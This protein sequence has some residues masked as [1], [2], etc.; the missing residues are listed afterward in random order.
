M[1]NRNQVEPGTLPL[2]L[3]ILEDNPRD[4]KLTTS[5]LKREGLAFEF[6]VTDSAEEFQERLRNDE[7][8]IVVADFNL[9]GWTALHALEIV[10]R[11]GK[12]IPVIVLTGSI[13]DEAAVDLIKRGA[14]D[15]ILK[16]R[17]ARLPLAIRQAVEE[18]RLRQERE[19]A[20]AAVRES[21]ERYRTLFERNL[22]GVIRTTRDGQ[23][24]ECNQAMADIL[25]Y[26]SPR[27]VRNL[28]ASDLYVFPVERAGF[29]EKLEAEG[30]LT[31]YEV[32]WRRKDGNP[33]WLIANDSL[34]R[35]PGGEAIIEGTLI[36]IT[37]RKRA[38][39]ENSRLA[40]IVHSS[41][42]AIYST[43]REGIISTWNPGAERMYGYSAEEIKGK[44]FSVLIPPERRAGLGANLKR[45]YGG[46]VLVHYDRDHLRKDGVRLQ[47]SSTLSP[48]RDIG[49][50]VT[51]VSVISHDVTERKRAEKEL[52]LKTALLEAQSETTIDGILA[53]DTAGH[54]LMANRQFARMW[55]IPDNV[56]DTK[57]DRSVLEL[58]LRQVKSPE[59]FQ[60][61]VNYLYNYQ[62]EESRDEIEL[63][64]GRVFDRY[65]SPLKDSAGKLLGRIWYFRDITER[66][67][68]EQALRRSAAILAAGE[69][70]THTGSW[71]WNVLSGELYWSDETYRIFGFDPAKDKSSIRDTFLARIHPDDRKG[72]EEGLT[73]P[74][75]QSVKDYR[76]VLPDG[77]LRHIHDIAYPVTDSSGKAVERFGVACD[78]TERKQAEVALR[79]SEERFRQIAETIDEVFWMADPNIAKMIYVSPAYERVW[80]R[81]CASLYENPRSFLESVHPDDR[82]RVLAVLL[83]Q[84]T[85]QAFDHE[86]RIVV[87][88]GEVRWVWDRGFPVRN[89]AGEVYRFV[90]VAAD[91]TERKRAEEERARL[92]T[93]IEQSDEAVLMTNPAGEIEYVNPAFT[94]ITGYSREE[95]LGQNPRILKSDRQSDL[96]YQEVWATIL[97]GK[98]WK[99]ELINRRKDGTHYTEQMAI[100]P[101][102][103]ARGEITHFIAT[104]QD[105]TERRALE[106]QLQQT[107]KIEA[108][109]RLAGGVAHDFNNLLTV[110]NGYSEILQDIL[111][112][113]HQAGAYLA[114]IKNAGDRA[115]ALTRQLLA[116]SRRQVLAPQVLDLNSVISNV[117][118]MLRRLIG[119]DVKLRTVHDP[120]LGRVKAD[121]GQIEQV[122]MNLAVNARDA[123]P[124]GGNLTI[125]TANVELDETYARTHITVKPGP[126]VMLA[127]GDTGIGMA[128]ETKARIFEP[129]FT[130]KEMG[131]GTGLGL[132]TV[133]GI[134]KQ[135]GGS[136]WVYSELGQGTVFKVYFP[137]AGE[138]PAE[139][140]AVKDTGSASGSETILVVED[141]EGVRS[142][143]RLALVSGGYKVLLTEDA[144][145]ALAMCASHEGPIHLL[146]TDVVMPKM[147]GPAVAE[148]VSA[149]RPGM[150]VLF[151]SGYTDDAIVHHGVLTEGVP[152]I[153]KP[154]SPVS[155]RQKVREV[156]DRQ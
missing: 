55:R 154:F 10:K 135:S 80:G 104:K 33:A 7:F 61:R 42:D 93:A 95:A 100:T 74:Q 38:E 83:A 155:L 123:M 115:A 92:V 139:R 47:V 75:T 137:A 97:N 90:G 82:E 64:D 108:V 32:R 57:V 143:I 116:F 45:L 77:S 141:E 68:A 49:G 34:I 56:L 3:L 132:A 107:A 142:L 20:E 125:E 27:E 40:V 58:A 136:I 19:R 13:G 87:P 44:H 156:L 113:D 25:G 124:S 131:K 54:I 99:G 71:S 153:Q 98:T 144:E 15:Y 129:F 147:S 59:A 18:K 63:K 145:K 17:Q 23:I 121:P 122:I 72:V 12:D 60:E 24:L 86:Y 130:T 88:G 148:K 21:E 29:L 51:G 73:N 84:R 76:I 117:E 103:N 8:D 62:T 114:E 152:F 66:K 37:E 149:L 6:G 128:P 101:V 65:S 11:S 119:E 9:R 67:R 43:T 106:A 111:G 16:D 70:L 138:A 26:D 146:L 50:V 120:A 134:V 79:E 31:N 151:M 140:Q 94:W 1:S 22:A 89:E 127:V 112:P 41:D 81:S 14:S 118:K 5:L 36:D 46:E 85:G 96:F 35:I 53:V 2:R 109:G 91:I 105:V 133:Y 150:K 78:I 28:R 30:R 48:I 52:A 69:R 39:A 126:H 4:A 110:I 102:R